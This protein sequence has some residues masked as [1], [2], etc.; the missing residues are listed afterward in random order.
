[1]ESASLRYYVHLFSNKTDNFE[2][3]GPNL[4]K[5][6]VLESEFQK[7]GLGISTSKRPCVPIFCQNNFDWL[8][9]Q[10]LVFRPKFGKITQLR[11]IFWFKYCWG[12]CRELGGDRNELGE[13]EWRWVEVGARFSNTQK[14]LCSSLFFNKVA[15]L[16]LLFYISLT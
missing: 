10:L 7:S 4:P 5:K 2:F 1:M 11:A 12:C 14:Q 9:G 8:L 3:L 6:W 16:A 13:G 15:R